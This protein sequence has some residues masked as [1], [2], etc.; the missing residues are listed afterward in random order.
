MNMIDCKRML[1][2]MTHMELNQ[3]NPSLHLTAQDLLQ[4]RAVES[5]LSPKPLTLWEMEATRCKLKEGH[6]QLFVRL[7]GP[8][9]LT[10]T[11]RV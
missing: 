5:D 2:Q 6:A 7:R 11:G 1:D 9:R 3:Q 4:R 8:E 10:V